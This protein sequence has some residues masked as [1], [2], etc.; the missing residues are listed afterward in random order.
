MIDEDGY[1]PN[2]GIIIVNKEGKLFWGK[3]VHQDAWQF[4]QGGIRQSE[5]PQ[6]AVFRELKEEVGLEPK[7]V[8]VL[9]RTQEWLF[10]DLPK[11]LIRHNSYPVCIGQKQ[12]WFMLGFEGGESSIDLNRHD[13]PEFE[14]WDWVEYWRP[15]QEVVNFKRSV[16][17]QALTELENVLER[18][19]L[20]KHS[21]GILNNS[22]LED[23]V[24]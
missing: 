3:R 19:W 6:Q 4:P 18:F 22:A 14:A 2:V 5:T 8:R 16:Y 12:I 15:V 20:N 24:V 21:G 17:Q 11:H 23:K 7:D 9:G 13:T 1:R 10:Y